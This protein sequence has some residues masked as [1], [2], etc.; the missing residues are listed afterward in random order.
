MEKP[1]PNHAPKSDYATAVEG[2]TDIFNSVKGFIGKNKSPYVCPSL[3]TVLIFTVF[4]IGMSTWILYQTIAVEQ[5]LE[6][7]V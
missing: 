4:T 7:F 1:E 5:L 2:G 6:G 3:R